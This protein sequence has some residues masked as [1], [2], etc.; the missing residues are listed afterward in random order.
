MR[1]K[2][3]AGA[4]LAALLHCGAVSADDSMSTA[5]RHHQP[6]PGLAIASALL[7]IVFLPIRLPLTLLG[8]EFAGL[9]GFLN[10]GDEHVADDIFGL[11]DGTQVITPKVLK[12]H[13]PFRVG[14]YD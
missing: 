1:H 9:S 14:R 8:A 3:I 13:E 11:V 2:R 5:Q 12:G 7:N 4:A 10:A 6:D